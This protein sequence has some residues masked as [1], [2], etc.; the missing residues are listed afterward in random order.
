M[1]IGTSSNDAAIEASVELLDRMAGSA[2]N[3]S[4]VL[5]TT[6]TED[7]YTFSG[8]VEIDCASRLRLC[9]AACCR[10]RFALSVQDVREKLIRW[11]PG[12]PYLIAQGAE[13]YCVHVSETLSCIVHAQRPVACRAYDCR[14]D[15]RIWADF[16]RAEINPAILAPDWPLTPQPT[17]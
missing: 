10:L 11:D 6:V 5:L 14:R 1:N 13:N 3:A 2:P 9:R 12:A 16:E 4:V 7:K 17:P 15:V 8:Q